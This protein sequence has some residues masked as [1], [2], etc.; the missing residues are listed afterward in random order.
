MVSCTTLGIA[1]SRLQLVTGL[2]GI[3]IQK[4]SNVQDLTTSDA[5]VLSWEVEKE[6]EDYYCYKQEFIHYFD[7]IF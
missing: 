1:Q 5:K 2:A 3:F 6:Q 7:V 4:R